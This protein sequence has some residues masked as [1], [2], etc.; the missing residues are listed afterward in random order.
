MFGFLQKGGKYGEMFQNK[1][2][3]VFIVFD[4]IGAAGK[5]TCEAFK[6]LRNIF[7][8]SK[9]RKTENKSFSGKIKKYKIKNLSKLI[10]S[11]K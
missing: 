5:R 3:F 2:K 8:V 6:T 9:A 7:K 10:C 1:K 4:R 11:E